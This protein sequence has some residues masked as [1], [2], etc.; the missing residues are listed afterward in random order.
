M[1]LN[2]IAMLLKTVAQAKMGGVNSC[3]YVMGWVAECVRSHL[4]LPLKKPLGNASFL[5]FLFSPVRWRQMRDCLLTARV[6]CRVLLR[7]HGAWATL[8]VKALF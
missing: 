4:N 8:L 5:L 7:D 6:L 3:Q 2:F 1:N